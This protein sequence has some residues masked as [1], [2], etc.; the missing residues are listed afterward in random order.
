MW[1]PH[2][3]GRLWAKRSMLARECGNLSTSSREPAMNSE[4][5]QIT[6]PRCHATP[7]HA[8]PRYQQ[9]GTFRP[10]N[11]LEASFF[12]KDGF[13]PGDELFFKFRRRGGAVSHGLGHVKR[14]RAARGMTGL[15]EITPGRVS[16]DPPLFRPASAAG[17]LHRLPGASNFGGKCQV[18]RFKPACTQRSAEKS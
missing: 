10:S 16:F 12:L 6:A 2:R 15:R 18:G 7:R 8:T 1:L 13:Q 9:Q 3:P 4:G 14:C 11:L 17:A 5:W